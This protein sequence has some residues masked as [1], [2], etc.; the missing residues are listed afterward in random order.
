[1]KITSAL[2]VGFLLLSAAALAFQAAGVGMIGYW[3]LDETTG[4]TAVDTSGVNNLTY[5]GGPMPSTD[6]PTQMPVGSHSLSF[7]GIDDGLSKA[8][9]TGL[10]PGNTPHSIAGWIKVSTLPSN[11]AWILLLGNEGGGSHHWLIDKNGTTQFGTWGGPG[12]VAP[13]LTAG[14]WAHVAV[15]FDGTNL[16]GYLNGSLF[17]TVA[18][19]FN[20]QGVALTVGQIHIGENYFNGLVDDLRVYSRAL[21]DPEIAALAAGSFGPAAPVGLTATSGSSSVILN[22]TAGPSGTA[23]NIKQSS[24]P[25][26]SPP[27]TYAIVASDITTNTYT[28]T[29]L[30]PG[31]TYY[32]VISAGTYGE[33]PN[34]AEVPGT[35]LAVT[36]LPTTGLFTSEVPTSTYFTVT[37]EAAVPAGT[38]V[39]LTVTSNDTGEGLVSDGVQAPQAQITI[40][41]V[42]PRSANYSF[43]VTVTGVNDNIIDPGTT[44]SV[45][46]TTSSSNTTF[47]NLPIPAIQLTNNDNDTAGVTFTKTVGLRTTE[48]AGTD[49]VLVSL[50]TQP[51]QPVTINFSSSNPAEVLVSPTSMTFS[52]GNWSVQQTLTLTGVDDSLLDFTQPFTIVVQPLAAPGEPNYDNLIVPSLSGANLDDEVIPPAKGAWGGGNG[53]CGLLGL[54]L[55]LPWLLWRRRQRR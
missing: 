28:V 51:S 55:L 1:M 50:T 19:N 44:Y 26:G 29:G 15:T 6:I 23:Y 49:T 35:P 48:S 37:F 31:V 3:P 16:K 22:W 7:D 21:S 53:G 33:S 8:A 38:T 5:G 2:L 54:E 36:A 45:T 14:V 24:A 32:F 43:P 52:N 10:A 18:T 17:N 39:T 12:Q 41:V 11:R 25:G 9:L 4:T 13:T 27:G 46:V 40:P 47:N 20:L 30:T 42:G 34:S